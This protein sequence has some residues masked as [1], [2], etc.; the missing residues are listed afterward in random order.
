MGDAK[1]TELCEI[2]PGSVNAAL[3]AAWQVFVRDRWGIK[4]IKL[5]A[6]G[7]AIGYF[8]STEGFSTPVVLLIC[9]VLFW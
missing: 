1:S 9:L 3:P 2:V 5:V 8:F 6:M 7:L 4:V